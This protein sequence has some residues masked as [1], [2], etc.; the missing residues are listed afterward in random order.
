MTSHIIL[1]QGEILEKDPSEVTF[2]LYPLA[3]CVKG[4]SDS[5]TKSLFWSRLVTMSTFDMSNFD[6]AH[7]SHRPTLKKR[8][9]MSIVVLSMEFWFHIVPLFSFCVCLGVEHVHPFAWKGKH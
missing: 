3:C 9:V 5:E 6:F 4:G 1:I 8:A 2:H 7:S